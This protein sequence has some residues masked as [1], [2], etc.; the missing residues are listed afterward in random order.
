MSVSI[1]SCNIGLTCIPSESDR[2][3]RQRKICINDNVS[4]GDANI[5]EVTEAK[6]KAAE[7]LCDL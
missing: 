7:V 5:T 1:P 2:M 3:K 6:P 4:N